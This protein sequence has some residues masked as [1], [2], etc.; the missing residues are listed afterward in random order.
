M[1]RLKCCSHC[2]S[3]DIVYGGVWSSK[4]TSQGYYM[5]CRDCGAT[6]GD[7]GTKRAARKEW[8]RRVTE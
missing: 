3:K 7:K 4:Y 8:N 6:S 5:K 2:G 1:C